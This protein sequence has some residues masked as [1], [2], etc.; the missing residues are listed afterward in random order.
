[1]A[2]EKAPT[3]GTSTHYLNDAGVDYF[4]WQDN[5]GNI[6]GAINSRKFS[7]FVN[8]SD[9]VMDFGCGGGH[10]P[11]NLVVQRKIGVEINPVARK[12][13]ESQLDQVLEKIE[14]V[15]NRSIDVVVSNHALEHV[16][17]PIQ[18]LREIYRVLKPGGK[19]LLCVPIDDWRTQRHYDAAN[20]NN[21][22]NTWSPQ[23][24]GNSL[25]EAG[26]EVRP[27]SLKILTH[28]WFPQYLKLW[29]HEY[30]FDV[31]CRIYSVK[32]KRRQIFAVATKLE[33]S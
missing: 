8:Q 20:I 6:N 33:G 5:N 19:L 10:M 11:A 1:M 3:Y 2:D 27:E 21:H 15:P 32:V 16:P 25:R 30:L 14:E 26:F 7:K 4:E 24:L 23:I 13:A 18:A 12:R 28:A 22:L 29:T 17:F 9:V 31:L